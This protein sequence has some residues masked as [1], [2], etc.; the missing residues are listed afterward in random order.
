M[1]PKNQHI[2]IKNITLGL[3]V[4]RPEMIP[5]P[6]WRLLRRQLMQPKRLQ[7]LFLDR[8]ALKILGQK[9]HLYGPGDQLT[10]LYVFH[11]TISLPKR[12]ADLAARSLIYAKLITKEEWDD[13]LDTLPHLRDELTCIKITSR[14][15]HDDCRRLFPRIRRVDTEQAHRITAEYLSGN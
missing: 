7:V 9:R 11:P 13:G 5:Y 3:S 6:L 12:E 14:L 4:H 10:L 15:S 8:A 1:S 2:S